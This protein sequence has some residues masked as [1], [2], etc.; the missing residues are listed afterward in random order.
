MVPPTGWS[1]LTPHAWSGSNGTGMAGCL[2]WSAAMAARKRWE[3]MALI[4][5]RRQRWREAPGAESAWLAFG[6]ARGDGVDELG[7]VEVILVGVAAGELA[8]G[9]G[10]ARALPDVAGDGHGVAGAGVGA[11]ECAAAGGGE[12]GKPRRDQLGARDDLHVPELAHVVVVALHAAP[13]DE[14]VGGALQQPLARDD[15]FA[16]AGVGA[17]LGVGLVDGGPGL[18]DLQEQRGGAG[19]ALKQDEVDAHADAAD[20]HDL[21]DDVGE[22]EPVEEAAPVGL[23]CLPVLG[24]ELS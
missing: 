14:D 1:A 9:R 10:E 18:L 16:V 11:G 17:G 2:F 13:A 22:G 8:D 3:P 4:V 19:A 7:V 5:A 23:E 15:P 21:A 12:L 24:K 20:P 6:L